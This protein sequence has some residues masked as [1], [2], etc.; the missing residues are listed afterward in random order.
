[1][2]A[3]DRPRGTPPT[4]A[5]NALLASEMLAVIAGEGER[6]VIDGRTNVF[7]HLVGSRRPGA[8]DG[9]ADLAEPDVAE[10]CDG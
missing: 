5:L 10:H 6:R 3:P 1:M 4:D 8:R 7:H 9:R 2:L